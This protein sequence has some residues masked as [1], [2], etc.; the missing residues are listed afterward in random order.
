MNPVPNVLPAYPHMS[1][2]E[3][4]SCTHY[5]CLQAVVTLDALDR[6]LHWSRRMEDVIY[7]VHLART[8]QF[9][10]HV[11]LH[12]LRMPLEIGH[13]IEVSIRCG[14]PWETLTIQKITLGKKER[15]YVVELKGRLVTVPESSARRC[16][17]VGSQVYFQG[18][19][20]MSSHHH[21]CRDVG[22]A[23]KGHDFL[24]SATVGKP[25]RTHF[26]FA[27]EENPQLEHSLGDAFRSL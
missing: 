10:T 27:R 19:F 7:V 8:R 22:T 26:H 9:R 3:Y 12:H 6:Y 13:L 11:P 23:Y 1:R 18:G 21:R 2:V 5:R 24:F 17:P 15:F 16:F 20:N 25:S 14:G 4:F